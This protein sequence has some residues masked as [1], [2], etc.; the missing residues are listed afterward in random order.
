LDVGL[1]VARRFINHEP[2]FGGDRGHI[3]HRLLDRGFTPRG[4]ALLLYA[5]CGV[6]A[7][8]SL[9]QTTLQNRF[10]GLLLA[11]F[12]GIVFAGV[13]YL[14]YVEFEAVR[15]FLWLDFRP[16]L[17]TNVILETFE[18][19]L[20]KAES[21]EQC[22][23]VLQ[24]AARDLGNSEMCARLLG[25]WFGTLPSRDPNVPFWAMRVDLANGDFV[26]IVEPRDAGELP[27]LIGPLIEV[28]RRVMPEKLRG[29]QR[30]ETELYE[31][32]ASV[33]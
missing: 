9:L 27:V 23:E 21:V 16:M 7:T 25:E 13:R 5:V 3:H 1:A 31:T 29:L 32:V 12:V 2:V 14:G 18:R 26:N 10:T 28:V 24:R 22:W 6:G 11:V 15:R 8:L 17:R 4:V 20:T 33:G 30:V 19:A